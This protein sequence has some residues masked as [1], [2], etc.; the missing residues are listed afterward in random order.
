MSIVRR[1]IVANIAGR[2]WAALLSLAVLPVYIHF[3]GIEAFG[4]IGFFLS[5]TAILSLLD[6]GLGTALNRQFA[7]YSMQSGKAQEMHDLLRTLE[8]IYW[9]IGV[10]IGV[11][12][13]ALAPAIAAYWLKPQQLSAQIVSQA[14]AMMGIA[15]AFQWPRAL[16]GGGL[17]GLQRQVAFNLLSSITATVNNLGGVLILWLVSPTLQAYVAWF[18]AISLVDTLS[19]GL[20]LW[21][22]LPKAPARPN[23][24]GQ[25]LA[26]IWRFAAGMTGISITSVIQTQLDKVI[27]VK[28]LPLDAFGYYSLAS[29]VAGGLSYLTSPISA[30][31]FPRFSQLLLVNDRQELARLYHR[32]CQLMS[33]LVLPPAVVLTL[34]SYELLFLWTQDRS[35]AENTY[36]VLSLLAAGTAFN[37]LASLPYALQLASGWT[38]LTLI[39]NT[40]A[41]L[42]QAPLIYIMSVKYSGVGAAIVWVIFN[43][44]YIF[45]GLS[46]MHRRLLRGELLRWYHLDIGQPLL[47]VV[48]VGSVW[49]WLTPFSDTVW[50]SLLNLTLVSVATLAAAIIAAP[51]IRTLAVQ[52][53]TPTQR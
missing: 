35:I 28:V 23:F 18:M 39:V 16:Y 52:W 45:V 14:L 43:A 21:R 53:L 38:R 8:V 17:V 19:T 1:N 3:L 27:L 37:A 15:I 51:E 22:S 7:Q 50:L 6:L 33:V 9:L 26:G 47:A 46:L 42:L 24:S 11:T 31:F 34:F 5:V 13:A 49:K 32:S 48:A 10:A 4:L 40:A 20:L 2:G 44:L 25:A 12:M 41:T 29:R 30:A 36:L